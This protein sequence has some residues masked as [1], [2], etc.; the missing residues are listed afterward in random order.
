[1]ESMRTC[2]SASTLDCSI[3]TRHIRRITESE[4]VNVGGE[5]VVAGVC[6]WPEVERATPSKIVNEKARVVMAPRYGPPRRF[7]GLSE[8]E[9]LAVH[10]PGPMINE[11][12]PP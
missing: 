10:C 5:S 12:L 2:A 6:V 4:L 8:R 1:M 7:D 9:M 3:P 11:F